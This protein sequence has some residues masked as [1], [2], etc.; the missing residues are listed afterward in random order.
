MLQGQSVG[1]FPPTFQKLCSGFIPELFPGAGALNPTSLLI[2]AVLALG[3]VYVSVTTPRPARQPWRRGRADRASS[4]L[5]NAVLFGVVML[6]H[7]SDGLASRACRTC[8]SS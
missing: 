5:K 1:P 2:G 3:L 6:F 7:L 4:S 8:W